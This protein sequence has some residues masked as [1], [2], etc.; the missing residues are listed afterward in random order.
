MLII[1]PWRTDAPVYHRPW[2][3]LGLILASVAVFAFLGTP[4]PERVQVLA[5]MHSGGDAAVNGLVLHFDGIR[6]L[7]WMTYL[8]VHD[9]LLDL[10][11]SMVFLWT[12]GLIVEGVVGHVRLLVVFLGVG[13]AQGALA[14]M[15]FEGS[16]LWGFWGSFWA[17]VVLGGVAFV[18]A[19]QNRLTV[20]VMVFVTILG[21]IEVRIAYFWFWF[22]MIFVGYAGL[23]GLLG[24]GL[25]GLAAMVLFAGTPCLVSGGLGFAIGSLMLKR[26]WVD[27]EDEDLFSLRRKRREFAAKVQRARAAREAVQDT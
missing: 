7:S 4:D 27:A 6:P 20:W 3:T 22:V 19:P 26:G 24:G 14:Q 23:L 18:W 13:V 11:I 16:G 5:G 8:F 17:T 12:F 1:A 21:N 15:A 9:G 2:A 10:V 25:T